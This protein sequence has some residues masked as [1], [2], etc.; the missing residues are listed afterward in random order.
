MNAN[1]PSAEILGTAETRSLLPLRKLWTAETA[2]RP[3]ATSPVM[4]QSKSCSTP[5]SCTGRPTART[6]S[7]PTSS[8]AAWLLRSM[9]RSGLNT[10]RPSRAPSII[11]SSTSRRTAVDAHNSAARAVPHESGAKVSIVRCLSGASDNGS[12]DTAASLAGRLK[13][14]S[15]CQTAGGHRTAG[16]VSLSVA[17]PQVVALR[18]R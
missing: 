6:G 9:I 10:Q 15:T 2:T 8:A 4:D 5:S 12:C 3:A 1:W 13:V 11:A 18:N 7:K 17:L 16:E 14:L